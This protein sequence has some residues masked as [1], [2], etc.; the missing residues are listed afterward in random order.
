M[1][2]AKIAGIALLVCGTLSLVYG[3]FSYTKDES[4]ID[5]GL[6]S[7]EVQERE[8]VD[9]PVLVQRLLERGMQVRSYRH[10]GYWLDIGRPD[11]YERAQNDFVTMRSRLLGESD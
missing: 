9:L 8:R 4:Q 6:V 1:H 11:D 5:L 10:T 7:V 3:G 2:G